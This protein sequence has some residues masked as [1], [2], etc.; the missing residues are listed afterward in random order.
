M[1]VKEGSGGTDVAS[2][3]GTQTTS[4]TGRD[5][6]G[7]V[8]YSTSVNFTKKLTPKAGTTYF[9][10]ESP[11][12]TD[13][14]NSVCSELQFFADNTTEQTN[15]INAKLQPSYDAFFNSA[16]FGYT[17]ANICDLVG[18]QSGYCEWQSWGIYGTK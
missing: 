17:W 1:G 7:Y 8:E 2:G 4:T 15:G 5:P 11:Q 18:G 10:N 9:V 13:S 16:Y 3:S 12:C 14:S 6:F